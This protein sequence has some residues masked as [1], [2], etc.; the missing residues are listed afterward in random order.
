METKQKFNGWFIALTG[1]VLMSSMYTISINCIGL[2]IKPISESLNASR[3]QVSLIPTIMT[4]SFAV[5]SPFVGK[6]INKVGIRQIMLLGALLVGFGMIGYSFANNIYILYILSIGMGFG[7]SFCT[8]IPINILLNNWFISKKGLVTGL[9]FAGS[10]LGGF[11]FTQVVNYMLNSYTWDR[12][13]LILGIVSLSITLPLILLF[14]RKTPEE[15]GQKPYGYNSTIQTESE[16]DGYTLSEI[17]G[18]KSF[19]YISIVFFLVNM[20]TFGIVSHFPSHLSDIGYTTSFA[21]TVSSIY[22][23]LCVASKIILGS[24]LDRNGGKLGFFLISLSFGLGYVSMILAKMKI[25][26]LSF[27]ILFSFAGASGT[28]GLAFIVSDIFGKKDYASIFGILTLIGTIGGALGSPLSGFIYDTLGSYNG[29]W[30]LYIGLSLV[31]YVFV[32]LAYKS[33]KVQINL[34]TRA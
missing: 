31:L 25:I 22:L 2:F 19:R 15:I 10:G 34:E 29:A 33:Q 11:V 21:A 9:V 1:F 16:Y 30:I 28:V 4:L 24:V 26:A 20:L 18:S 17:K 7:L 12:A 5:F 23:I 32:N 8:L 14:V 3:S 13:Y 6:I 27:G